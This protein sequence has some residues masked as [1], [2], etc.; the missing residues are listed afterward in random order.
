MFLEFVKKKYCGQSE[1]TLVKSKF[2]L[3]V[4]IP[5]IKWP[6]YFLGSIMILVK[7]KKNN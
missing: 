3:K 6:L 4:I 7:L 5:Q 1:L 2:R